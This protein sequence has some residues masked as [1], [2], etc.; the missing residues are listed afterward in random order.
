MLIF[1]ICL[2]F[3]AALLLALRVG[4]VTRS[5]RDAFSSVVPLVG[6]LYIYAKSNLV[7][8]YNAPRHSLL[9]VAVVMPFT[10]LTSSYPRLSLTSLTSSYPRLSLTSLPQPSLDIRHGFPLYVLSRWRFFH[11]IKQKIII[12]FF[13]PGFELAFSFCHFLP[14]L[15]GVVRKGVGSSPHVDGR[16]KTEQTEHFYRA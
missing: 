10:S 4:F 16:G 15:V 1:G 13:E 6:R 5:F 11:Q 2:V 3:R 8:L 7:S 14:L 9:G 12:G